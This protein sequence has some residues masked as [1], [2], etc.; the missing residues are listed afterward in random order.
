MNCPRCNKEIPPAE[1]VF[2]TVRHSGDEPIMMPCAQCREK[3]KKESA[4]WDRENRQKRTG[5]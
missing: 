4:D 5:D 2:H 3:I 1:R